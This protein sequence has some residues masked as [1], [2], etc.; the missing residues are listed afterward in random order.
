VKKETVNRKF[1]RLEE[2]LREHD[3]FVL[4]GHEKPDGDCLG[5]QIA[6]AALLRRWDKQVTIVNSDPPEPI[7]EFLPHQ[8]WLRAEQPNEPVD[9]GIVT[10]SG[11]LERTGHVRSYLESLDLLVNIDH[12]PENESMGDLNIVAPELSCVG[13][14]V[15]QF[16]D[17]L[18][19]PITEDVAL[20]LYVSLLTDTGSFRH[21]NTSANSHRMAADLIEIGDLR[22][23][24][25]YRN[26]YEQETFESTRLLGLILSNVEAEDGVVWG[27]VP[28]E[29][30]ERTG[31]TQ[32][33]LNNVI[34]HLRRI[35]SCE[36]AV[37]FREWEG[38]RVKINFRSRGNVDLL[39][40]VGEFGGG[41]HQQAAGATVEGQLD[42]VSQRVVDA[43]KDAVRQSVAT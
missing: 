5:S 29:Y 21:D 32:R 7:Y 14:I 43:L 41:G 33:D 30:L 15:Y 3:S 13:E 34:N 31:T 20:A 19:E 35:D 40:V 25:I 18:G 42:E 8:D 37:L 4:S 22:P 27:T 16:Y 2:V 36:V 9:V 6:L 17:Y 23:Y 10:D 39:D 38:G 28:E 12:H 24:Q 1:D 11:D 26:I